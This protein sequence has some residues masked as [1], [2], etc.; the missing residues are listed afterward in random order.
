M[1]ATRDFRESGKMVNDTPRYSAPGVYHTPGPTFGQEHNTPAKAD[2]PDDPAERTKFPDPPWE[3]RRRREAAARAR[4]DPNSTE[5][6]WGEGL[7]PH[8]RR[9]AVPPSEGGRYKGTSPPVNVY[10]FPERQRPEDQTWP[11]NRIG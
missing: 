2:A 6:G 5:F 11:G 8:H 1:A 9:G 10:G 7:F 4:R 3:I